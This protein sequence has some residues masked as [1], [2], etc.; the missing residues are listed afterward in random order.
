MNRPRLGKRLISLVGAADIVS[1]FIADW[2]KTHIHNTEWPPHAK[3]H[4]AQ[5]IL[6]GVLLGALSLGFLWLPGSNRQAR[7][8]LATLLASL[9]WV[10]QLGAFLFPRTAGVD[11][12]FRADVPK[13][14]GYQL[15]Q[16]PLASLM[17]ALLAAGYYLERRAVES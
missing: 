11:P 14:D 13:I 12:E 15:N 5:T 7:T 1:P 10:S 6:L 8:Q 17:L 4:D 9:Y 3:F 2:N 16:I